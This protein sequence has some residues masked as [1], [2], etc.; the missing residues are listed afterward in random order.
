MW[1]Y[2]PYPPTMSPSGL[3]IYLRSS[4]LRYVYA[5]DSHSR[6]WRLRPSSDDEWDAPLRRHPDAWG[7][8]G[9]DRRLG[10]GLALLRSRRECAGD[11]YLLSPLPPNGGF[12]F[13]C[14]LWVFIYA[15]YP[16]CLRCAD[17]SSTS[18]S[19]SIP[20]G[21]T[22]VHSW[23]W[24]RDSRGSLV[25]AFLSDVLRIF[26]MDIIIYLIIFGCFGAYC[27]AISEWLHPNGCFTFV[28]S[29]RLCVCLCLILMLVISLLKRLMRIIALDL[30]SLRK[31]SLSIR[32]LMRMIMS[33][34]KALL[35]DA[36]AP[37]GALFFYLLQPDGQTGPLHPSGCFTFVCY[38]IIIYALCYRFVC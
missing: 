20:D 31:R 35:A 29:L 10:V 17:C 27:W 4:H 5:Y 26:I 33:I 24:Y 8:D 19:T 32:S 3:S 7:V 28:C 15:S 23:E 1:G 38:L 34:C 14:S 30:D 36:Y 22:A 37:N 25:G 9:W 13:V 12:T 18:R 11:V 16:R 6:W 2:T 21:S